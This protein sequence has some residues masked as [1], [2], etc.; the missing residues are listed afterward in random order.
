MAVKIVIPSKAFLQDLESRGQRLRSAGPGLDLHSAK[1]KTAHIHDLIQN[2]PN[3]KKMRSALAASRSQGVYH[4]L[5]NLC[6][7][8]IDEEQIDESYFKNAFDATIRENVEVASVTPAEISQESLATL[9]EFWHKK[10]LNL[11]GSLT[12]RNINVGVID[13]GIYASHQEFAGK[14]IKF[15]E[16]D[17]VGKLVGTTPKDYGTHGTHVCGLLAGKNAGVAPDASLTVAACLTER[18]GTAGYLAQILGGL[19][20]LLEQGSDNDTQEGRVHLINASIESASGFNDYLHGA[21]DMA[22]TEPGTLM[23]AAIGNN[24]S[25][26]KNSDSSPGNY[27]LTLGIGALDENDQVA[28]FSSW[29]TVAQLGNITKPDISA[30]GVWLYSSLSGPGNQY[31][32]QSGTSMASPVAAGIAALLLER[33]PELITQPLKLKELL[34]NMVIPLQDVERAGKGR[35]NLSS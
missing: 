11:D 18:G 1:G 17:S 4:A 19:N 14:Q 23:I 26:G 3:Q 20:Y 21:L 28:S 8:V 6:T 10:K 35:I 33:Q 29:G 32:K 30:P 2:G 5:A 27:D 24:G 25:K 16:F 13:S 34:L 15:A 12:G 22:L 9:P 7:F 31:F